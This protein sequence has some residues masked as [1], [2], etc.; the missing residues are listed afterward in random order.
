MMGPV[1]IIVLLVALQRLGELLYARRNTRRLLAE[2]AVEVGAVHYPFLVGLHAAWLIALAALVPPEAEPSWFLLT[3]FLLLQAGRLWVLASLGRFW[4][5]RIISLPGVPLVRA[6]PYRYCRHPN[7]LIV[8]AEIA[9][10]P[11]A[12]GAWNIA[13]AFTVLNA[14]LLLRRIKLEEE[15]LADR[16]ATLT[17]RPEHQPQP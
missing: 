15:I 9:V 17:H 10:L 8:A 3:V 5:T 7:Y 14:G 16:R 12:F 13:L 6:G 2:G 1:Q 4:T 11:L